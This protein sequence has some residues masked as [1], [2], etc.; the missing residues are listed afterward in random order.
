MMEKRVS[1]L[2]VVFT[3]IFAVVA[4]CGIGVTV[5][6]RV[7]K[8]SGQLTMDN[9]TE[10]MQVGCSMGSGFGGGNVM[11][12]TYYITVDAAPYYALENV[13]IAYSLE[14]DGAEIPDGVLDVSVKAG[15]RYKK[16]CKDWFT[17]T[18][19]DDR[20]GMWNAP[21]LKITVNSVTGTY[22][23]SV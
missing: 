4:C 12:Y 19:N 6:N 9:Y 13:K 16:E 1:I 5:H 10:Y 23:Y 20:F 18:V 22:R 14:S 3:A 7:E 11:E 2:D 21:T 17:V 8:G 15:K